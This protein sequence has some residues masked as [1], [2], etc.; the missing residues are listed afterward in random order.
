MSMKN[1]TLHESNWNESSSVTH[2]PYHYSKVLAEKEA[3][4][5]QKAQSRWDMV[6]ICPGL[7]LGPSLT[8]GSDS[9]SLFLL[10]ELFS[11]QLWFGVPDLGF[12]TVDVREV[13]TAHVNAAS[14]PSASGRYV[15]CENKMAKFS[16]ISKRVRKYAKNRLAIPRHQLPTFL[17]WFL[18]PLF[19]L[20][21]K[22]MA[23]NLGIYFDID[24]ERSI[25]ELGISYRPLAETLDDHYKSW[26]ETNHLRKE[27]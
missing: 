11:G 26:L 15:V 13:V 9:G 17:I 22:W 19:G 6:A 20:T 27:I 7:V 16:D 21:R 4:K 3:W 25:K 12:C 1:N 14:N 5:M 23:A 18:G 2:N 10:D 8:A 24:N